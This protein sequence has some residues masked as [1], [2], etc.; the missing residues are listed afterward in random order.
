LVVTFLASGSRTRGPQV[1]IRLVGKKP[2][3]DPKL[4]EWYA[5]FGMVFRVAGPILI[6]IGVLYLVLDISGR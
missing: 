3:A 1:G 2:G 6:G 5:R 4:D